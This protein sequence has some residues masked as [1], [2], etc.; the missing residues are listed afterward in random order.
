MRVLWFAHRDIEH[1]RSGGAERTIFEI[2]RRLVVKG[3]EVIWASC[4]FPGGPTETVLDG[5]QI[6]RIGSPFVSHFKVAPISRAWR[7]DVIIDDLGHVVPWFNDRP[8]GPPGTVFF[9][10][11]H[12]RT[13]PGQLTPPLS[14]VFTMI[15]RSYPLVYRTWPFVTE[16]N[17][18]VRDLMALGIPRDRIVRIPPGVDLE[19]FHPGEKSSEPTMVYF[20]GFR[21]YK[22][23]WV[24]ISIFDRLTDRFPNLRLFMIGDGPNRRELER[25]VQNQGTSGI[26]FMGRIDEA[27]LADHLSRAWVNIHC[28]VSEG[29]GL[30]IFEASAAGTP[31]AAF[32]VPGVSEVVVPGVNG[33][34]VPDGNVG[35]LAKAVATI[36]STR[37][38]WISSSRKLVEGFSWELSATRWREHLHSILEGGQIHHRDPPAGVGGVPKPLP[39]SARTSEPTPSE[40][41]LQWGDS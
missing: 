34:L 24:P 13:L 5:V 26:R 6:E 38:R 35:E 3:D 32:S 41:T 1:S 22:R 17:Q 31:T 4:R 23:P 15:E 9:R 36:L 8:G 28:A 25:T 40:S 27:R 20:G 14:A 16:S 12:A 18:S 19:R 39:T 2:S 11:L 37:D 33:L 30:S 7:P 10:H 21:E 29:W